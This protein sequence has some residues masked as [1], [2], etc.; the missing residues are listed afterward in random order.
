MTHAIRTALSD[1]GVPAELHDR[2][3]GQVLSGFGD[4]TASSS[5]PALLEEVYFQVYTDPEVR[6]RVSYYHPLDTFC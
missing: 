5:D 1:I 6:K 3:V 4:T 2:L